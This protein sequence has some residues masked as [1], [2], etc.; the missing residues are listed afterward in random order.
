MR[1]C[2]RTYVTRQ[3][4]GTLASPSG[5][6]LLLAVHAGPGPSPTHTTLVLITTFR[7]VNSSAHR[8]LY[9]Q[10][11]S[12]LAARTHTTLPCVHQSFPGTQ[13]CIGIDCVVLALRIHLTFSWFDYLGIALDAEWIVFG[14]GC[15]TQSVRIPLSP[16]PAILK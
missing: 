11:P 13:G 16:M 12:T 10:Q 7:S 8:R 3:S 6:T 9:P 2:C 15:H 14:G 5:S 1:R 4:A